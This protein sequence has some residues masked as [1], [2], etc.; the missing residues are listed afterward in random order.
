MK[1][2][3]QKKKACEYQRQYRIRHPDRCKN[4]KLKQEFGITVEEY[5]QM[6]AQQN[7]RCAICRKEETAIDNW[8]KTIRNLAV[9]HCHNTNKIRGLLCTKCNT[10]IGLFNESS[11]LLQLAID[12]LSRHT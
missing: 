2:A 10:G 4:T 3:E 6:L 5:Y 7:N 12:Y 11:E 9:D 1:S 8:K